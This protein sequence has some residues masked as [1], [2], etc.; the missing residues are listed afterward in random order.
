MLT[1]L[2]IGK[3]AQN[4]YILL[5]MAYIYTTSFKKRLAGKIRVEAE[6][7]YPGSQ[8]VLFSCRKVRKLMARVEEVVT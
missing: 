5:T 1:K 2:T 4:D 8:E 6:N 7:A 3:S